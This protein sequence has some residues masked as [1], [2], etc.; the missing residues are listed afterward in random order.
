MAEIRI[1]TCALLLALLAGCSSSA[2]RPAPS[3]QVYLPDGFR[4]VSV[5]TLSE[6]W[7]QPFRHLERGIR[8]LP[9]LHSE[10]TGTNPQVYQHDQTGDLIVF[11][12]VETADS[13]KFDERRLFLR[14]ALLEIFGRER[15]PEMLYS[16]TRRARTR[17]YAESAEADG[18]ALTKLGCMAVSSSQAQAWLVGGIWKLGG[19]EPFRMDKNLVALADQLDGGA[20]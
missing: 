17:Q 16:R 1:S 7:Q 20:N 3:G 2:P 4:V 6:E 10:V 9:K 13:L 11:A 14:R 19:P 18:Q 15:H 12:P 8:L 5:L